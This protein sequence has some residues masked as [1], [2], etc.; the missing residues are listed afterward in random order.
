LPKLTVAY[1]G[2][3]KM[4]AERCGHV[5]E[6]DQ[7]EKSGGTD[8]ALPPFDIFVSSLGMC[9][10]LFAAIF[11]ERHGLSTEGLALDLEFEM[12]K[13]PSRLG[14]VRAKL[15]APKAD[16]G[17][18]RDAVLRSALACPVHHSLREDVEVALELAE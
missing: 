15:R 8:S 11:M 4:R 9:I 2:G 7:P 6:S 5:I 13:G 10:T 3:M 17:E 18:L 1:E 12:A 14:E 16:L